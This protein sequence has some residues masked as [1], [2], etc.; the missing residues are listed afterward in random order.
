MHQFK[1]LFGWIWEKVVEGYNLPLQVHA[2]SLINRNTYQNV[3]VFADYLT[4]QRVGRCTSTSA[5][6]TLYSAPFG[7]TSKC[8]VTRLFWKPC[9]F[10][11]RWCIC[12]A[13]AR[14]HA[15]ANASQ[16]GARGTI[17]AQRAG[18]QGHHFRIDVHLLKGSKISPC[19]QRSQLPLRTARHYSRLGC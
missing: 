5:I 6:H 1:V 18:R 19:V 13:R 17:P 10:Y 2:E 8:C 12:V 7:L 11:A 3:G 15:A 4:E 9:A 16:A 14:T